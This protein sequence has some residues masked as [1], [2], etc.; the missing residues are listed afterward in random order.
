MTLEFNEY[1]Q[2][3]TSIHNQ[4]EKI[5]NETARQALFDVANPENP[6]FVELMK[7]HIELVRLSSE[8]TEK[9]FSLLASQSSSLPSD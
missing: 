9:M 8:L 6:R 7:K 2:V 1:N 4:L 5:A 3:I